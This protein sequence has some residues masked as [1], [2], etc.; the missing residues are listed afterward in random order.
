MQCQP[1]RVTV[2]L[3]NPIGLVPLLTPFY[4]QGKELGAVNPLPNS[5]T[6]KIWQILEPPACPP[7]TI[8]AASVVRLVT[9]LISANAAG[10]TEGL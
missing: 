1:W 7:P 9:V 10:D 8:C 5:R 2:C 4:R 6:A 3:N